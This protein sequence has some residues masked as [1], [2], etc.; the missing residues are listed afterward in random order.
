MWR[1]RNHSRKEKGYF[2]I[3]V[4]VELAWGVCDK[5]IN[6]VIRSAID[7]ERA[8]IQRLLKIFSE[9]NISATWAVVGHLLL[10]ECL[11]EGHVVHPEIARP[12]IKGSSSDWFFQHPKSAVDACWY[13]TEIISQIC[14]IKPSQEIGSHSFA[15]MPYDE[16]RSNP[17][18]VIS[19]V[20]RA[21]QLHINANLPFEVFIFPRNK[22]GFINVLA[23]AG[24]LV[25]RGNTR[26]WYDLAPR[27][28]QRPLRLI[29]YIMAVT[30]PTVMPTLD[31]YELVNVP[32]SM[33]LL[34]RNGLRRLVPSQN[35][36]KMGIAGLN[37]AARNGEVFHLWFH[38]I[39]FAYETYTQ[40]HI[41]ENILE[42]AQTL[43]KQEVIEVITLGGIGQKARERN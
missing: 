36:I 7:S 3:S 17:A 8:T 43:I 11:W 27:I 4:D 41:L 2:I 33:L 42:H 23:K 6:S 1:K 21:K 22:V 32:D 37:R 13:G 34:S 14:S 15:H 19:D 18:A 35:L 39:N 24:I 26:R 20:E 38:P 12:V 29:N 10:T 5:P 31:S 40:F 9:F 30:P 25:Y 16:K 28:C